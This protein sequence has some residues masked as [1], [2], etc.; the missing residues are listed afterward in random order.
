MAAALPIILVA[1]FAGRSLNRSVG[2]SE[3]TKLFWT[4]MGGHTS[5]LVVTAL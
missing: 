2:E 4:V 1:T 3:D 5:R